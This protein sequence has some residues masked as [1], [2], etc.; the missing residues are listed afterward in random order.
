MYFMGDSTT[1]YT[2]KIF[3]TVLSGHT[4]KLDGVKF[5]K[6]SSPGVTSA[7]TFHSADFAKALEVHCGEFVLFRTLKKPA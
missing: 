6:Q 2:C 3:M 4:L 1:Y 7:W 5:S